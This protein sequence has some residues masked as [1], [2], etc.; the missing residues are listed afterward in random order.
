MLRLKD[1]SYL[2]TTSTDGHVAFW[3]LYVGVNAH[4]STKKANNPLQD[5]DT[6][7][8]QISLPDALTWTSRYRVHQNS[9]QRMATVRISYAETVLATAG[10]DGSIAFSRVAIAHVEDQQP[11]LSG[12]SVLLSTLLIPKAHAAATTAL[13]FW[14]VK[15]SEVYHQRRHHLIT[16]GNDQRLKDWQIDFDL[17]RPGV[18]GFSVRRRR[19]SSTAV[20]DV[21]YIEPIAANKFILAGIGME[22]RSFDRAA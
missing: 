16:S 8:G 14:N 10:D 22:V 11:S 20:A 6:P 17:G 12:V 5:W 19:D 1:L 3:P 21:S 7:L 18:E 9:I 2:C 15:S 4:T 13:H